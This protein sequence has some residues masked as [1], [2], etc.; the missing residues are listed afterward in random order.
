MRNEKAF[1]LVETLVGIA[2][3]GLI[4]IGILSGLTLA[5]RSNIIADEQTTAES[6]A[7]TQ[8]EYVQQQT[9]KTGTSPVYGKSPSLNLPTSYSVVTAAVCLDPK[10]DGPGDDGLQEITVTVRRN[11]NTVLRLTDYKSE[12]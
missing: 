2:I 4:S 11:S 8:M 3:L 10:N 7:R 9:Y 6:L 1:A 5:A 12:R